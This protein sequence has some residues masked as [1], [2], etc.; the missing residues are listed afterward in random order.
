MLRKD[1]TVQEADVADARLMGADAVLLIAAALSDAELRPCAALADELG[2]A[3][4]VE[5]HDE[6]ELDRALG[7]RRR[8][9][10]GSTSATC[11][12][13]RSTTSGP[14]RWRRAS[15]PAWSPWPSRASATPTTPGGWPRPATTPSWSARRSMRAADR[16]AQLRELVGHPVGTR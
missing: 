1:F 5:V 16:P 3:A 14:A 11:A 10:S 12:R 2:L 13:S 6:E 9:W 15:R 8:R 4:L 7:R